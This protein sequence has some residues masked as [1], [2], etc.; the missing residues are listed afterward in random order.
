MKNHELK[1]EL[2]KEHWDSIATVYHSLKKELASNS[3]EIDF[4][5][6]YDFLLEEWERIYTS[7][8]L[9]PFRKEIISLFSKAQTTDFKLKTPSK[10][11]TKVYA[12][13]YY[14]LQYFSIGI[15]PYHSYEDFPDLCLNSSASNDPNLV[16]YDI[17]EEICSELDLD[18]VTEDELF[19]DRS[20]FYQI[21]ITLLRNFLSECWNEAKAITKSDVRG[22][23]FEAT[24]ADI[25]YNLDDNTR[26]EE[27]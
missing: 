12:V 15:A 3:F 6:L 24:G 2:L 5:E 8:V 19:Y 4:D 20:E 21:E 1:S 16:L 26:L 9:S 13:H 10:N 7:F 25:D 22:I 23:L 14:V 27:Q 11:K 18:S 17:F